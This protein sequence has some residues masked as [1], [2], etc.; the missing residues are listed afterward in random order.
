MIRLRG[1]KK[2]LGGKRVLDGLDLDIERGETIVV[3][4]PSGTGKSVLLKHII[5]LMIPDEGS[6]EVDGVEIVGLGEKALDEV[7]KNFGM[8]FQGAA[9]FDSM[10]VG[11]NVGL[12]LREHRRLPVA[13]IPV[14]V[15]ECLAA[16]GLKGAEDLRTASLSGG[17]RKRVGL[18]RAIAMNPDFILY[19]EP[20]TGLDPITADVIDQLVRSLQEKMG[21]TSVVV[22]HDLHSAYKVGDRLAMLYGGRV[23]FIGTPDEVR[24]TRDPLVRQFIEGSSVGPIQPV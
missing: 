22:T 19:D 21:V 6:I 8:L 20:T 12:A 14:R 9:L 5:G 7:R 11:E 17:M 18:A 15:A 4:G 3:L 23:V 1:V 10:S 2:R 24:A 16:V 13:Q